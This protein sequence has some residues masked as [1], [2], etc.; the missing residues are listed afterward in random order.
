MNYDSSVH[1]DRPLSTVHTLETI[2]A[3]IYF[4]N[5]S[6]PFCVIYSTCE[7]IKTIL[8]RRVAVEI[9]KLKASFLVALV[10]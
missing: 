5:S 2:I 8:I 3:K 10:K 1:N 7:T 6:R 9:F 4:A